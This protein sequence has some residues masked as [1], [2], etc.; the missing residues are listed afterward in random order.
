SPRPPVLRLEAP[1]D[2]TQRQSRSAPLP[3]TMTSCT[4]AGPA[5]SRPEA[6]PRPAWW[7]LSFLVL[8][9]RRIRYHYN[10][11]TGY[12]KEPP[13]LPFSKPVHY[14]SKETAQLQPAAPAASGAGRWLLHRHT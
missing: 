13:R 4:A 7:F 5:R 1:F 12:G 9:T 6:R 14:N 3:L 10:T 2:R 8:G 11:P